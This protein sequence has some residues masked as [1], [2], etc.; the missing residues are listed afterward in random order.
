M[1]LTQ[2]NQNSKIEV[3]TNNWVIGSQ[4]L[5]GSSV[6]AELLKNNPVW[7]PSQRIIWTSTNDVDSITL[8][9]KSID[10]CVLEFSRMQTEQSWNIYWCA[11]VGVVK[12]SKELLDIEVRAIRFLLTSLAKHG[13]VSC[14]N[15]KIFFASSA[16]GVYA[17]SINPPFNEMSIP[18]PIS[19]YGKQKI[20]IEEL[21]VDF[22]EKYGVGVILGRIANLYGPKQNR[23]KQQGLVTTLVQHAIS[24]TAA[25]LY[26]PLSTIRNYIYADDAAFQIVSYVRNTDQLKR[27]VVIC[28]ENNWSLS[29]ILRMTQDVT[30]KR[31][32][33]FQSSTEVTALQ[34]IDLRLVTEQTYLIGPYME[35][36]MV[37][38]LNN[39]RLHLLQSL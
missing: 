24:N 26:V 39:I 6:C 12:S 16:G 25:R 23:L 34:P 32:Y 18:V 9:E 19:N 5:L 33:Y 1:A 35:T 28:S 36:P 22:G 38:G 2:Q 27:T 29:N 21:L 37:V 17:G 11:G 13:L 15:S 3:A 20:E 10:A 4:G 7:Q 31:M 8:M 30:K 14:K